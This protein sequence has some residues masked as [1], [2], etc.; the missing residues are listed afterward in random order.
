MVS[1]ILIWTFGVPMFTVFALIRAGRRQ[2][3]HATHIGLAL[4]AAAIL[5]FGGSAGWPDFPPREALHWLGYMIFLTLIGGVGFD[6]VI[7]SRLT[8][9][10]EGKIPRPTRR[11]GEKYAGILICILLAITFVIVLR[12][13][14]FSI[15]A[16]GVKEMMVQ[17]WALDACLSA[18]IFASVMEMLRRNGMNNVGNLSIGVSAILA[19]CI[20]VYTGSARLAQA[21][22]A[23]GAAYT[24]GAALSWKTPDRNVG[25][26][27]TGQILLFG[28]LICGH[29]YGNMPRSSCN[30]LMLIPMVA[31][32]CVRPSLKTSMIRSAMALICF[33]G[34]LAITVSEGEPDEPVQEEEAG[35]YDY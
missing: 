33:V 21:C 1:S 6:L 4:G 28:L 24:L 8:K 12:P 19:G 10:S 31:I 3:N 30:I 5:G 11:P 34:A 7:A 14:L 15:D 20:C 26:L 13:I 9:I 2:Q 35:D 29:H 25:G 23:L 27:W 32:F 18:A 16:D 22:L 17:T